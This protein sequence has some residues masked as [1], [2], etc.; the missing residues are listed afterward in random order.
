[1]EFPRLVYKDGG[2]HQRKG[3]TYD[4]R[5]VHNESE[6][7]AALSQGWHE[8]V[9]DALAPK[10]AEPIKPPPVSDD[11]RPP[12]REELMQKATELGIQF[13]GRTGD[14]KLAALIAE[15]LKG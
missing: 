8:S 7:D 1:M 5:P 15:K 13:D 2:P 10:P 14:K 3:G 9:T 4:Y 12:T 6:F 11:T